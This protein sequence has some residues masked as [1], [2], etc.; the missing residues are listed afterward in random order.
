V[1]NSGDQINAAPGAQQASTAIA[2]VAPETA[3]ERIDGP[4]ASGPGVSAAAT[5]QTF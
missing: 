5:P 3:E 1:A 4:A 2:V